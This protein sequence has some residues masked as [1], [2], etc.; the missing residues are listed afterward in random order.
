[1]GQTA[2]SARR[3][4]VPVSLEEK[5]VGGERDKGKGRKEERRK[6]IREERDKFSWSVLPFKFPF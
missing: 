6:E 3:S 5:T 1:M 2:A 4:P